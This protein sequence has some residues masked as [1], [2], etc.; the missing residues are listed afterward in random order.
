MS[1]LNQENKN[2]S[3]DQLIFA[4][5]NWLQSQEFYTG[6]DGDKELSHWDRYLMQ[7]GSLAVSVAAGV[8]IKGRAHTPTDFS[9]AKDAEKAEPEL[10]KLRNEFDFVGFRTK[11][12]S[13]I[14]TLGLLADSLSVSE[15]KQVLTRIP[16]QVS[17]LKRYGV[18]GNE[19]FGLAGQLHTDILIVYTDSEIC[20]QHS[21]QVL[22]SA[23]SV[24]KPFG[25]T[26]NLCC[27]DMNNQTLEI[28]PPPTK[29]VK[30]FNLNK[31]DLDDP[32]KMFKKAKL[33]GVI[34]L[35]DKG[36]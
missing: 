28:S 33:D 12:S 35:M 10:A 23:K 18:N 30:F 8:L 17:S 14:L 11:W 20:K 3:N 6:E 26:V 21:M 9:S 22:P 2:F 27:I 4:F 13:P 16:Q 7:A 1:N 32:R 34:A 29:I 15:I 25:T 36:K 19:T 31:D 24:G 5:K